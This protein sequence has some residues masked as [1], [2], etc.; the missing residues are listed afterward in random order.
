MLQLLMVTPLQNIISTIKI[1]KLHMEQQGLYTVNSLALRRGINNTNPHWPVESGVYTT[2]VDSQ[3][4]SFCHIKTLPQG[5]W[6]TGFSF[7]FVS[8]FS[9][10]Y[11]FYLAKQNQPSP[12]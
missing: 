6:S 3:F 2:H 5:W 11:E 12:P 4:P 9:P 10:I 8:F 7:L 1:G